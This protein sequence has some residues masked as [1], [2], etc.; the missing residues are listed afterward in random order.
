MRLQTD[1][2]LREVQKLGFCYSCGS[3]FKTGEKTTKDHIPPKAIFLSGDRLRPLILPTH[4]KCN[5]VNSE[6]DEI[7]GQLIY[8]LH[9]IYPKKGNIKVK[10]SLYEN[11]S[12]EAPVLG[13]EGINLKGVVARFVKAFHAALYREYLPDDTRNWFDPPTPI[14]IKKDGKIKFERIRVQF[15]L[16]VDTLKKNRK[17]G[18]VDSILCFNDKCLYEC[19]WEQMDDGTWACIFG[20]NIYNWKNLGDAN[21]QKRGCVGF[22]MPDKGLP[23]GATTGIIRKLEIPIWNFDPL[24]PFGE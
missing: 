18:K 1:R 14:G 8:A 19:V 15:P 20:L 3:K 5:N 13:L 12:S 2:E 17:A 10:I 9:G 24:D 6:T 4:L 22:Y 23:A 21:Q 16:F 7:V 11:A